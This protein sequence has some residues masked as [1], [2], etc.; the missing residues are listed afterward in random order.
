M[1]LYLIFFE[2]GDAEPPTLDLHGDGHALT[3]GLYLSKSDLSRSELYHRIKWQ[4]RPDTPLL[5]A[6]LADHPKFKGMTPGALKWLRNL[7]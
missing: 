7:G 1:S 5:V 4:L 3:D 6:P 2:L